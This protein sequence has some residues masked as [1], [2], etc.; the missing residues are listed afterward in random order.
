[1]VAVEGPG[2]IPGH[3]GGQTETERA[4]PALPEVRPEPE[5]T[6]ERDS[7]GGREGNHYRR[8]FSIIPATGRAVTRDSCGSG[9]ARGNGS[10]RRRAGVRWSASGSGSGGGNGVPPGPVPAEGIPHPRTGRGAS[11]LGGQIVWTY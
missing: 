1:M 5:T 7:C 9:A 3:D 2:K 4:K 11:D 8:F 6:R 10:A